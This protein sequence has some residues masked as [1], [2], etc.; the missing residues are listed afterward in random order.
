MHHTKS[1]A[2]KMQSVSTVWVNVPNKFKNNKDMVFYKSVG[3]CTLQIYKQQRCDV[4]FESRD[5]FSASQPIMLCPL[6]SASFEMC[7]RF[8]SSYQDDPYDCLYLLA[9]TASISYSNCKRFC[10]TAPF[11][12]Q[13][14]MSSL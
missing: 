3:E 2:T 7:L 12:I 6:S 11:C 4:T 14:I 10:T 1:K 5:C 13:R 8:A 9:C